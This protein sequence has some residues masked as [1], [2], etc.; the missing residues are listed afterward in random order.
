MFG[1]ADHHDRGDVVRLFH[2]TGQEQLIYGPLL[3]RFGRKK[4]LAVGLPVVHLLPDGLLAFRI[5]EQCVA[6]GLP[7]FGEALSGCVAQ[8]ASVAMVRDF[9]PRSEAARTVATVPVH[10]RV[11][12]RPTVG[13]LVIEVGGWKA[14]V[15]AA[16]ARG[17]SS[18]RAIYFL[19]PEE[20][21][22][23]N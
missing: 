4:P 8:V 3:D 2:R 10:R 17:G 23:S 5:E 1:D 7:G 13:A 22:G 11:L 21:A 14:A 15:F 18:W 6:A 9:Y 19:L 20:P 12:A 16:S